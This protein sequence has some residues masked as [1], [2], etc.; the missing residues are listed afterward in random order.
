VSDKEKTKVVGKMK[1]SIT[2]EELCKDMP[3][4]FAKYFEYVKKLQFK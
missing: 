1:M 4:E 2:V 3:N